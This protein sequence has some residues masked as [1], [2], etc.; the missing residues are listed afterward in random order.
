MIKRLKPLLIL[1]SV[2]VVLGILLWVLVAFVLPKDE[3]G[4]EKGNAVVLMDADLT[5]ADFLEVENSFGRYKLIKAEIGK[6]YIEGKKDYPI[7]S[8]SVV[9]LLEQIGSLTAVKKVVDHPS[10]D[11]LKD[12]G[13]SDPAATFKV[14]DDEN[15]YRFRIGAASAS[16]NYYFQKEGEESVYL[17]NASL[18]DLMLLSRHQFYSDVITAYTDSVSEQGGLTNI[19]VESKNREETVKIKFNDEL[20]E[21]EAG[22]SYI[23]TAPIKHAVSFA[24]VD[25]IAALLT[26]L[27]NS[28]VVGDDTSAAGLEKF[29]LDQPVSTLRVTMNGKQEIM[30]FGRLNESEMQYCYREGGKFVHA[31]SA[32]SAKLLEAPLLDYCEDMIYTRAADELSKIEIKGKEKSYTI[33][34]GEKD[35]AGNMAV[36]INNRAVDSELFSDFYMHILNIAITGMD[37]KPKEDSPY[38]A[39]Q[40]TLADE[41]TVETME[42]YPVS[43][44]KCSCRLNGSGRFLVN[45]QY[46]DLIL[47]NAQHLYDGETIE[48]EW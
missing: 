13:L 40:F 23:M 38:V 45:T 26:D 21:E 8:G 43:D 46:V 19:I 47:E 41:K 2:A 48:L 22:V 37:E 16:G 44:L 24:M 36:N 1:A 5:E 31:V 7:N 30:H 14:T 3:A 10:E 42:F 25:R 12:Y 39:I 33:R 28:S 4:T 17:I 11:Q 18:P 34:I 20:A 29:G 32:S 15:I 35:E 9:S 6:Y 27:S